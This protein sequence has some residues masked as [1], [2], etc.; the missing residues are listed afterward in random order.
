MAAKRLQMKAAKSDL[1]LRMVD[2]FNR[3]TV[4]ATITWHL[5]HK[6]NGKGRFLD[7]QRSLETSLLNA[8]PGFWTINQFY[9]SVLYSLET[10][11]TRYDDQRDERR[12]SRSFIFVRDGRNNLF[13]HECSEGHS[14]SLH[15]H[16]AFGLASSKM[17]RCRVGGELDGRGC[18]LEEG[19]VRGSVGMGSRVDRRKLLQK[20]IEMG[21]EA[22]RKLT[23][24][25]NQCRICVSYS[26]SSAG[27]SFE[28]LPLMSLILKKVSVDYPNVIYSLERVTC[29]DQRVVFVIL[30]SEDLNW[31]RIINSYEP[32]IEVCREDNFMISRVN[33]Q[34]IMLDI[35]GVCWRGCLSGV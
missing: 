35:C 33:S 25:E 2:S 5:N 30:F 10:D 8:I 9:T 12:I 20:M 23:Q 14:F 3:N 18:E 6:T 21:E 27:V 4:Q 28:N 15:L 22:Q 24:S 1:V 7:Y 17:C 13:Q 26:R 11:G 32:N 19:G 31:V 16:C 29:D 34:H